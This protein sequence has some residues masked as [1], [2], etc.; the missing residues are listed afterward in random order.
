VK[1][2]RL[3]V[4]GLGFAAT[5]AVLCMAPA[6]AA[7]VVP[8][9]ASDVPVPPA[10]ERDV[11]DTVVRD[12]I[13]PPIGR[14]QG[15]RPPAI[16][17]AYVWEGDQILASGA[18]TL[19]DLLQRVPEVTVFRTGWMHSVQHAAVAGDVTRI[20]LFL[21]DVELDPID[22]RE[23]AFHELG[24]RPIWSLQRIAIERVGA[25][26]RI[27][28]R[29]WTVDRTTPYTRT[30]VY[31][32]TE[33][34]DLYRGYYGKRFFN[35]AVLQVGAEQAG[36]EN[37]RFGGGGD[38]TSLLGRLGVGRR[39]WSVDVFAE[40]RRQ[41]RTQQSGEVR[42]LP[43]YDASHTFAYAR[44]AIGRATEG[45]F[46]ELLAS[47]QGTRES[48]RHLAGVDT[49]DTAVSRAQYVAT[50]G[51]RTG[52]LLISLS[53]RIRR[54]EGRSENS[55]SA[56]AEFS[57]RL[58]ELATRA[59]TGGEVRTV[60][61]TARLQPLSF[62]SVLASGSRR[63][64]ERADDSTTATS[65][66]VEGGVG[67]GGIWL[68]GGRLTIDGAV[69]AVNPLDAVAEVPGG[70]ELTGGSR[71]ASYVG[72]RGRGWRG[73]GAHSY[74]LRWQD[75]GYYMPEYQARAEL[76]YETQA[77][78]RFPSGQFGFRIAVADEFR[79]GVEF[80]TQ[81]VG[82]S[83]VLWGLMEIRISRA[84]MTLRVQNP[85]GK[86]YFLV[87]GFEMPRGLSTYG[88]RWYFWG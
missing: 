77:L 26:I 3:L 22:P 14:A 50:A 30:D 7:Q 84:T 10:P 16:G 88:I 46:L 65:F 11:P 28:M 52:A 73:F 80:L 69:P 42:D 64:S 48:S 25:E 5:A 82:A 51:Y 18:F 61:G 6:A 59:E 45:P 57:T 83:H 63:T 49:V 70:I 56:R 76:N 27:D 19:A 31:T 47:T 78:S 2:R 75:P 32:G 37:T 74:V 34:T 68:Y 15:P 86:Q 8:P 87:P 44:A 40:R 79:S 17:G 1:S 39:S 38:A 12:T 54:L 72:L 4:C 58:L 36:S 71:S 43:S 24:R 60:D 20:R 66:R 81:R 55:L 13:Q 23:F 9:P 33:E 29:S 35:G 21:D 41:T 53:D 85:L 62:L 67:R